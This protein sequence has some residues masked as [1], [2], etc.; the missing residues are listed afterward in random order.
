MLCLPLVS[1]V[2]GGAVPTLVPP[3][4]VHLLLSVTKPGS[5]ASLAQPGLTGGH[6]SHLSRQD[7][8]LVCLEGRLLPRPALGPLAGL[9]LAGVDG[10]G[11]WIG[12]CLV[13]LSLLL[14][15]STSV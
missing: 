9:A 7:G 6:F 13:S 2:A 14:G 8:E 10:G 4:A 15:L 12:S 3:L 5:S 1:L 11:F